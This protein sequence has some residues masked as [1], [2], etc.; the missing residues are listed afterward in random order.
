LL[1]ENE[2]VVARAGGTELQIDKPLPP[3]PNAAPK[4]AAPKPKPV[5][6]K[7]APKPKKEKP[8]SR[9]EKL[10]LAAKKQREEGGE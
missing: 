7:A 8:L 9:L 1:K 3:K 10:R 6:A 4:P 2:P 5:V